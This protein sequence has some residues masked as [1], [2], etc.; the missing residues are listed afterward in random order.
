[1]ARITGG[2]TIAGF[3]VA[4][5][6]GTAVALGAGDGFCFDSITHSTNPAELAASPKGCGL[7]M[8][9]NAAQGAL[10]P[11]WTVEAQPTYEDAITTMIAVFFGGTFAPVEQTGGES[12]YLHRLTFD[13]EPLQFG[14]LA[15]ESSTTTVIEYPSSYPTQLRINAS[16]VPNFLSVG[17]DAVTGDREIASVTNTNA[18]MASVTVTGTEEIIADHDSEF[19]IN[20]GAGALTSPGDRISITSYDLVLTRNKEHTREIKGTA[21]L[22][23]PLSEGLFEGTLTVV[24]SGLDDH[25]YFTAAEAGTTYKCSLEIEGSQINAG[26][27]KKFQIFC[28][29]M[30]LI[31]DPEYNVT[32]DGINTHTLVFKLL[33]ADANPTGMDDN[34][35]YIEVINTKS[36]T[37]V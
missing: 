32:E 26:V 37:Y 36:T 17:I 28:P 5:T 12:D 7:E 2:T 29:L 20:S 31:E 8:L 21:G 10:S 30:K 35:P 9:G 13:S 1:M 11:S 19:L 33:A 15:F 16:N 3:D 4:S 6:F 23:A 24:L 34:F 27:N 25:T 22:S 18:S 14:T